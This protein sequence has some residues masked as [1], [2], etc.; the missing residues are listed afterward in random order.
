MSKREEKIVRQVWGQHLASQDRTTR[1]TYAE[2]KAK[3]GENWGLSLPGKQ[4]IISPQD[5]DKW[6][7]R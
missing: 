7:R 6:N 3:Y 2:M 1:P 4:I 5:G